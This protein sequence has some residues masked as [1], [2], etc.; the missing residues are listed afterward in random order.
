[1]TKRYIVRTKGFT[2]KENFLSANCYTCIEINA[3]SLVLLV[4]NLHNSNEPDKFMPYLI[5]SQP[6]E[7]HFRQICSFSSTYSTVVVCS[8]KDMLCRISKIQLQNDIMNQYSAEFTFPRFQKEINPSETHLPSTDEIFSCIEKVKE[9]AIDDALQIGL[10][11]K[12]GIEKFDY[13][14]KICLYEMCRI[15][16]E[17]I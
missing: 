17:Q 11:D 8:I 1:M 9:S 5:D 3:H 4:L 2:L 7:S 13:R 16:I 15:E 14:C 12:K 10:I 6:C